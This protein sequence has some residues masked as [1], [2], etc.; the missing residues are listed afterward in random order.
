MRRRRFLQA[1]ALSSFVVAGCRGDKPRVVLYCAQ[2]REFAESILAD[3]R[4]RTGIE[5]AV[6]FDSEADKSVGLVEELIR[7]KSRPRCDV[8]WNNE[9]IGSLRL[10]RQGVLAEYASP[11]AATYPE[12][13]KKPG[14][15]MFA[16]RARVLLVNNQRAKGR[17]APRSLFDLAK[18]A[19]RSS[20]AMARPFFGTTATHA[21]C[22][23]AHLGA[24]AAQQLFRDLKANGVQLVPGNK[25]SAQTV[26]RGDAIVGLT[27][28]DDA[29]IEKESGQDVD[30]VYPDQT[31][32]SKEA[33]GTLFLPNTL[34]LIRNGPNPDAARQ[35]IDFLLS[36]EVEAKLAA[37]SS[38]QIPLNPKAQADLPGSIL[39]PNQAKAMAVDFEKAADV[40]DEAQRFL[41]NLFVD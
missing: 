26:A 39:R 27:D 4:A 12:W 19:W 15:Q 30:I 28:T 31:D 13:T 8:F 40:W 11:S 36:P 3:F 33:L 2:D 21:A 6:K 20:F 5:T 24:S 9:V 1:A 32:D 7:E 38:R 18:P 22:L 34:A 10:Q 17:P 29:I 25:Q 37:N 35:L 16:A 41:R 23:F 14:F